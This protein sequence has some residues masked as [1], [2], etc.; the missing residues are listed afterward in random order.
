MLYDSSLSVSFS[1]LFLDDFSVEIENSLS[2]NET[3]KPKTT[4]SPNPAK[5]IL[6]INSSNAIL[7]ITILTSDARLIKTYKVNSKN[8]QINVSDLP[9]G[10]YFLNLK[11][12]K[13]TESHKIIKE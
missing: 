1:N 12:T 9:S 10:T 8:T 11:G 2:T 3:S 4:I 5:D 13:N 7:E 6:N